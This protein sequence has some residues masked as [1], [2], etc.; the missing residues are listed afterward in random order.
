MARE[1]YIRILRSTSTDVPSGLTF[2]EPAF[3]DLNNKLF[4]GDNA[5]NSIWIGGEVT[6][7]DI[8][9]NNA[10]LVP[11]QAAVKTY[12]DGMV[13][14]GSVVNTLNATGGAIT[15]TGAGAILFTQVDKAN[16][17][18]ARL[19]DTSTTG[20]A[21]YSS[22]TF[23]VAVDGLVTVKNG[24][25]SNAQ[26]ANSSVTINTNSG[27]AGGGSVALGSSI[28]LTNVGVTAFN[29]QTGQI[30]LTGAG[31]ILYSQVGGENTINA[32]LADT[33][34]TGVASF[35]S[36]SFAVSSGD[37]TI[38]TGGV[39]NAQLANSSVTISTGT[40]L[41]GGGAVSLGG[42]LTLVNTGVQSF[43]GA[44]G[45][46]TFS[47]TGDGGALR[48]VSTNIITARL[49]DIGV[50][51]VASFTGDN[52]AVSSGMVSIKDAGIPNVKLATS[53]VTVVAG[54]NSTLSLGN[55]LT[56][57]GGA[58]NNILFSNTANTITATLADNI[59]IPGNLTVN[60]T[61]VTANVDTFIAKDSLFMLGTGNAADS[62]DI[63]FY[64]QY[65]SS[66][67]GKQFTGLFR[68]ATDGKYRLFTGLTGTDEP[69]TTVNTSG[70]GYAMATLIAN[71]DGG[72]F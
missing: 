6:G 25:I 53:S 70:V 12:V 1:S 37:V 24:G 46:I 59:T 49:A 29:G 16:T 21:Y 26:L 56:F 61:V 11:T 51:G 47:V 72:T 41:G 64:G 34:T 33:S 22:S 57:T 38:K 36:A 43:N 62:L 18:N 32:R 4:V 13:G 30:S 71:I 31:A 40:G 27:L 66:P 69:G 52:F 44:T 45:A 2:G 54:G 3:S 20:V 60:G 23:A 17:I 68:D 8:A 50:T 35:N 14:G 63:G 10:Y 7:G 9:N 55:T 48:G 65:T 42:S 15:I 5:G 39:S 19:A 58:Q 67:G 28:T